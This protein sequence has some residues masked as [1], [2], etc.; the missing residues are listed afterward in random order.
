MN[1]ARK[2]IEASLLTWLLILGC[3]G[4]GLWGYLNVGRL[5]DP[6]FTIKTAVVF[7]S[8]P[9]AT[10]A[11]VAREVTEP[12]ESAIQ[13]MGVLDTVTSSNKPGQSRIDVEIL[14]TVKGDELPQVWDELRNRVADAAG[15]LPEGAAQPIVNDDFGDVFGIYFAVTAPGFSD[16]EIHEISSFLRREIL[17]VD[18]VAD[19]SV[20]G[21][22]EEAVYVMPDMAIAS[23][24]GVPP[25]A[26][27]QQ[28]RAA[29][30]IASA[31]SLAADGKR[32]DLDVPRSTDSVDA[33]RELTIN[34]GSTVVQMT[35]I[36]TVERGRVETPRQI[37]RFNGQEAFTLGVSGIAS[38]NIVDIGNRVDAKLQDLRGDLPHGVEF[39]P[40]Y[41]QHVVVDESSTGFLKNLAMSV[42]LVVIVLAVFMGWR[43][44]VVVGATLFL[45][46]IGTFF[47]MALGGIEM[48]RISLGALII[49]MGMLVDN[50]IVVAEAMQIKMQGGKTSREAA[51]E[52]ASRIQLPLLGATVIGIMAFAGI[53][54][55]PDATG[56]FLF[57]LFAVVGISL[58]LSWVLALTVTP[59][60][61]HYVFKRGNEGDD[62]YSGPIFNAYRKVLGLSLRVR[63]LFL[64]GMVVVTA[65]CYRGFAQVPQQFFPD[66]N[67]P[68]FYAHYKLPQ[69]S[70]IQAVSRDLEQ[71][72]DWLLQRDDVT[73]VASFIGG[74]ATRFM[75]TYSP[76]ESMPTYG[77][78]IIRTETLDAIPPLL[79]DL[80][81]FG[82]ETLFAG[83]FRTE[84]LAFGPGGGV[85]IQARISGSDPAVL[86]DLAQ[87][88]SDT[89]KAQDAPLMDIRTDW[90]EYEPVLVPQ[91]ATQR[92]QTAGI[93]RSDIAD[94]SLMATEGMTVA[95]Y[96]E[97]DR[98]IPIRIRSREFGETPDLWEQMIYSDAAGDYLRMEQLI[99][100]IDWQP[101]NTLIQRR[102]RVPTITVEAGLP[103]GTNASAVFSQIRDAVE[104]VPMPSGYRMEWGGEYESS[105]DAQESLGGQLPMTILIM[106]LISILL[107]G[108]L[109]QPLIVWLL[110]PMAVNGVVIGLLVTGLPFSFTALLGLLSLSGMLLKNGIVLVEEIDLVRAEGVPFRH[111]IIEASTSRLRPVV[112][113][114]ATTILGMAP[115]LWDPFFA[116]M[117]VTIM[118]GLAFATILTLIAAPTFYYV[119]FS[120]EHKA[121]AA[122]QPTL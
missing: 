76:E 54:L 57:S 26:L 14:P 109:R 82:R 117:S 91:Y 102:N 7:T 75:L 36:A 4:G 121:E 72:E 99:D 101:R 24:L 97:G 51:D 118:G 23:N 18:G 90:R 106:I 6:A 98:Q 103:S 89:L 85:P 95:T 61:A 104:T 120:R 12:L 11:Q 64:A 92:A 9:G 30:Q 66:S 48:E 80:N 67:T 25:A 47:F 19:V 55:S 113:A 37:I 22:P 5:E 40:I 114:A 87:Q 110:V 31:G 115:L 34:V 28:I 107:F 33:L 73:S 17:T 88:V 111:A 52:G 27:T 105:T 74:G 29:A 42:A 41:Q 53:G 62:G 68:I 71:A 96:Q 44:A 10:A 70:D 93:T 20:A 100:Q 63:W 49:A 59:L 81:A 3:L 38:E 56:E 122:I 46:V 15:Q 77:H 1:L 21:L 35:D 78:L 8:Y 13:Q 43:S 108:R 94:A 50:S 79:D 60:L 86:R 45:N 69:G 16:A 83:E 58:L 2:A 119:L 112:L 84:R 39:H 32:F 116:S 65:L